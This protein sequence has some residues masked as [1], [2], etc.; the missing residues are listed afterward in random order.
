MGMFDDTPA[1]PD[2]DFESQGGYGTDGAGDQDNPDVEGDRN[3]DLDQAGDQDQPEGNEP[4][5]DGNGLILGKYKTQEDLARA[6]EALQKRLG[7]MRN[8]LGQL[9]QQQPTGQQP[10]PQQ[11]DAPQ[12]TEEQW[13][14]F[15]QQFQRD[16]VRNPGRAVFNLVNGVLEQA[17]NPIQETIMSQFETQQRESAIVSE[18]GMMVSAINDAGELLFPGVEDLAAQIDGFLEQNPYLLDVIAQQGMAR[19]QGQLDE[20]AMGVLEVIYKAVQAENA[21]NAGKQAYQNGLQQGQKSVQAK[22]Q[23]RLPNAGAKKTGGAKTPEDQ[24]VAEIFAH[25]KGGYFG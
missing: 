3:P 19:A 16:F 9:R 13:K 6:H 14:Q 2:L 24:I 11:D 18:L 17:V 21:L 10:K 5:E 25:R 23:A 22:G 20:S 1:T 8:E 4:P 15:D 12:W 7:D